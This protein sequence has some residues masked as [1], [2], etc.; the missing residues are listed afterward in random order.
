MKSNITGVIVLLILSCSFA[1]IGDEVTQKEFN[2]KYYKTLFAIDEPF[3]TYHLAVNDS[4]FYLCDL[5]YCIINIYSIK[6]G[7]KINSFGKRGQGPGD[8]DY[9]FDIQRSKD[10]IYIC[11]NKK[12]SIFTVKGDIIKEIKEAS[13]YIYRTFIPF[14]D[15]YISWRYD[16]SKKQK[17]KLSIVY[18]LLNKELK[19]KKDI[20]QV[21]YDNIKTKDKSKSALLLF[22]QCRKGIVYRDRFYVGFTDLG[23]YISVF[24]ING[25]KLYEIK[26]EYNKIR[27]T[28]YIQNRI[29][30]LYKLVMGEEYYKKFMSRHEIRPPEFIPAFVNFF[31]DNEKIYVFKYP[32]PGSKGM[33]EV[34]LLDL[35]GDTLAK[36]MIPFGGMYTHLEEKKTVSFHRGK[37]YIVTPDKNNE[38]K[39]AISV[40]DIE[41]I[42]SEKN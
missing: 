14:K 42:F 8:F 20:L 25:N 9:I 33:I 2:E 1:L 36:K 31:V 32:E 27:I 29:L 3:L 5:N 30:N 7:K 13:P 6:D 4:F 35:M 18:T 10:E 11:S 41:A 16:F 38:D 15:N 40:M 21:Y 34:I 26:K 23:F 37:L 19:R 12:L 39:V 24:D 28:K 22:K 17:E